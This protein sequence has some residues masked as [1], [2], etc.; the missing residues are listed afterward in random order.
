VYLAVGLFERAGAP[1]AVA[2]CLRAG[3]FPDAWV[4]RARSLAALTAD[5]PIFGGLRAMAAGDEDRLVV[6]VPLEAASAELARESLTR[7]EAAARQAE[8][9]ARWWTLSVAG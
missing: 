5:A 7:V 2:D 1:D 8:L 9:P 4:I 3:G 6:L